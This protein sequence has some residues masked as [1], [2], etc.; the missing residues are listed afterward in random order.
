MERVSVYMNDKGG[1]SLSGETK[2][3]D[4]NPKALLLFSAAKCAALTAQHIMGRER[5]TP[6]RLE[7]SVEGE[8]STDHTIAET[9][10]RSF[11]IC[12]NVEC[13][14]LDEQSRASHAITLAHDKYCGL[15]K[16]L[17][18]IAP[19]KCDIR[20]VATERAE[21]SAQC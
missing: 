1:F 9:Y 21:A 11:N 14:T 5:L 13:H 6:K 15:V 4:L 17:R 10:F 8:T 19:V 16:M 2:C 3:E 18:M 20:I 7:V 12:Y